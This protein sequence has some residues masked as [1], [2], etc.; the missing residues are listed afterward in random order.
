LRRFSDQ[1]ADAFGAHGFRIDDRLADRSFSAVQFS[2]DDC[3][4]HRMKKLPVTLERRAVRKK[5]EQDAFDV[6]EQ[7]PKGGAFF[8]LHYS[9]TEISAQGSKTRV[10]A[11]S[12]RLQDGK[13][14]Q[15]SFEGELDLGYYERIV[16]EAQQHFRAQAEFLL[17]SL[18]HFLPFTTY[19]RR[20]SD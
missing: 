17:R 13:L 3:M 9:S 16:G 14:T 10:K 8:S 1:V 20:D 5:R 4:E 19:R 2:V 15:E 7:R 18:S 12:A 6:V 11:R